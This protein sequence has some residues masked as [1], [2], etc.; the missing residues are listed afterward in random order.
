MDPVTTSSTSV[1]LDLP[2]GTWDIFVEALNSSGEIVASG[3]VDDITVSDGSS[4][5]H[6]VNLNPLMTG[7]GSVN[8]TVTWPD[9][10]TVEESKITVE[11]DSTSVP[12]NSPL[13]TYSGTEHLL[14]YNNTVVASGSHR[15]YIKL[16]SS[17][18]NQDTI[19]EDILVYDNLESTAVYNRN[20]DDFKPVLPAPIIADHT[21]VGKY[22]DIPQVWIDEVKKMLLNIPGESHGRGY[23]YGLK[24]IETLNPSKYS[25]NCNLSSSP[26]E[27]YTSQYLRYQRALRRYPDSYWETSSGEQSIW[28]NDTSLV[29]VS[30]SLA[31]CRDDLNNSINVFGWA[32]CWDMVDENAPGG[33]EDPEYYVRWAGRAY[34]VEDGDT[35][36]WGL[37]SD[38]TSLTENSICM[39]TYIDAFEYYISN[40]SETT[41]FFS[42]G[43]IDGSNN[44][45]ENGY[46]RFLK[47]EFIRNHV[48]SLNKVLFDYAD[49][50][51]YNNAGEQ[52]VTIWDGHTYPII[53]PDNDAEY[54]G[55]EGSC[56]IS[57]EGC[58]RIGKA[59]WWMLARIAGW[60]GN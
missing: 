35:G 41:F 25:V 9:T 56:H 11:F 50:L 60:D 13:I 3:S 49:I 48:Q 24:L 8:I 7:A 16:V 6:V 23:Y 5:T 14:N 39:R 58:L 18:S 31:Y 38:D 55:G 10:I 43:P 51:S 46:Q 47:H 20:A 22:G 36:R 45:G 12:M 21:V 15:I 32:W 19:F 33:G 2:S 40:F 54:D 42:T 53:H 27:S 52:A 29:R 57:E 37:D 26:P 28:T 59:L 34:T 17:G 1:D 44:L 4:A 30:G